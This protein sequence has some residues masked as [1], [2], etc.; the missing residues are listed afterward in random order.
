MIQ[1]CFDEVIMRGNNAGIGQNFLREKYDEHEMF[2]DVGKCFRHQWIESIIFSIEY[3]RFQKSFGGL[4][5]RGD[6]LEER[7]GALH[8]APH[9]VSVGH[10]GPTS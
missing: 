7:G 4:S 5:G 10:M 3:K 6:A 1:K 8:A 2:R 9:L